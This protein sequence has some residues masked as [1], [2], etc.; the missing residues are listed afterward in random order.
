MFDEVKNT[1]TP[2]PVNQKPLN[3]LPPAAPARAEDIFAETDKTVKPEIFRPNPDNPN[4]PRGT[5]MPPETGWKRNKMVVL[6]LL[7]GGLIIIVAGGYFGLKLAMTAK[8]TPKSE[9]IQEQPVGNEVTEPILDVQ[10]NEVTAPPVLPE[11]MVVLDSDFDGLT[12]EEE[13]MLGTDFNNADT[14]QD[15]LTDREEAKVYQTDPL[16][17]DTDGDGYQDGAEVNNGYNPKG[18]GKLLNINQL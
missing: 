7:F 10:A 14:D 6:G 5:V 2:P 11:E 4:P 8:T 17:P 13:I 18:E 9:I 3:A 1:P 16:N 15:G 12:D